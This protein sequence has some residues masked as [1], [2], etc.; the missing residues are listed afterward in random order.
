MMLWLV[1]ARHVTG[2]RVK[3]SSQPTL[4]WVRCQSMPSN[5]LG[6]MHVGDI[7]LGGRRRLI[8]A[9]QALLTQPRDAV[10]AYVS[11]TMQSRMSC[12]SQGPMDKGWIAVPRHVKDIVVEL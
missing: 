3:L 5:L 11:K 2:V 12:S 10:S 4:R 1:A 7:L 8:G 9:V 6:V